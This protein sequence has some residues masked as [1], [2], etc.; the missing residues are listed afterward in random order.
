SGTNTIVGYDGLTFI[1]GLKEDN[2]LVIDY[3]SRRCTA[4]F[5]FTRPADGTLPTVGPLACRPTQ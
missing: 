2:H 4:E 1:D 5:T 3:G